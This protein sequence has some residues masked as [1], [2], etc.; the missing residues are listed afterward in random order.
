M[1]TDKLYANW[2]FL[3]ELIWIDWS[4]RK[5]AHFWFSKLFFY[6]KNQPNSS[7]L[8][9]IKLGKEVLLVTLFCLLQSIQI[10]FDEQFIGVEFISEHIPTPC[11]LF[12]PKLYNC[13]HAT[14]YLL[15]SS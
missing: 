13:N 12:D 11:K 4:T 2:F 6:V 8:K 10:N 14:M 3:L 9:N 15:W 5:V 7:K 1:L